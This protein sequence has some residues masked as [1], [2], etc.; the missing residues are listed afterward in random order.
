[1]AFPQINNLPISCD[2]RVDPEREDQSVLAE[3]GSPVV[4]G[5][6]TADYFAI[7]VR[8]NGEIGFS[9]LISNKN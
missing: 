8:K 7:A 5:I 1:L 6:F 9:Y 2:L 3:D 4:C